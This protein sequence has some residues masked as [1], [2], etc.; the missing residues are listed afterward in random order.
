MA[1]VARTVLL[2]S[3]APGFPLPPRSQPGPGRVVSERRR[4]GV[5]GGLGD[6]EAGGQFGGL[7]LPGRKGG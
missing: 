6:S 7:L 3:T 2:A 1:P 4:G 5:L